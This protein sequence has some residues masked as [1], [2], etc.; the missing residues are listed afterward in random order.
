MCFSLIPSVDLGARTRLIIYLQPWSESMALASSIS[1]ISPH[2]PQNLSF[3]VHQKS[4]RKS[5]DL[6][7][8]TFGNLFFVL[9][10]PLSPNELINQI[11]KERGEF[12]EKKY[13]SKDLP[14]DNIWSQRTMSGLTWIM[15]NLT[16]TMSDWQFMFPETSQRTMSDWSPTF[17]YCFCRILLYGWHIVE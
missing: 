1:Q 4:E 17:V 15:S 3:W 13:V 10:W 7:K 12:W 14:E 2:C 16:R 5:L 8:P 11:W 9:R 6:R